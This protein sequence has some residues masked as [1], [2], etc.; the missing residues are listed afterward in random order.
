MLNAHDSTMINKEETGYK[1]DPSNIEPKI[2]KM[3]LP[4]VIQTPRNPDTCSGETINQIYRPYRERLSDLHMGSKEIQAI[5]PP[6]KA[7]WSF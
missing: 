4:G 5:M 2:V 7:G 6:S 1:V 3:D